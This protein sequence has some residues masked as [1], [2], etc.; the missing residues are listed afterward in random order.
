MICPGREGCRQPGR[1][2][3]PAN[4]LE[5]PEVVV[6]QGQGLTMRRQPLLGN[7]DGFCIQRRCLGVS[8]PVSKAAGWPRRAR[9]FPELRRQSGPQAAHLRAQQWSGG[10]LACGAL[11]PGGLLGSLLD[12]LAD[13]PSFVL[14]QVAFGF[15]VFPAPDLKVGID[16]SDDSHVVNAGAFA[17]RRWYGHAA[18]RIEF[19]HEGHGKGEPAD[20][21]GLCCG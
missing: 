12:T 16:T 20:P 10:E 21:P 17:Q 19:R 11:L 5:M 7:F 8:R 6:D 15:P 4:G 2:R 14:H 9:R 1:T 18:L 3:V 13:L